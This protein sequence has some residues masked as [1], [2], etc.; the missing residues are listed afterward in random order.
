VDRGLLLV[1]PPGTGKTTLARA[2]SRACGIKF[3]VASATEWQAHGSLD[4]HL[5]AIRQTF[6]EARRYAPAILFLDEI[7]S[8]GSRE[9]LS[10]P[11]AQY[12]TEVING[13]L[14]Q[15]QGLDPGEPVIVIGATNYEEHVDPALRRAGRLDQVVR[16]PRPSVAALA[17][18]FE[19]HLAEHR[20]AG[21]V[22]NDVDSATLA[23]L[24][25]GLTGA[26]VEFFVRGAARR[27]RKERRPMAQADLVAEVT[28]RSRHPD[29]AHRLTPAE[30]RRVAVH[31]AGHALCALLADFAR[32]VPA[33]VSIVPRANGTLGF[34]ATA[35]AEGAVATRR[36]MLERL[37]T[38]LAGRAAEALVFGEDD[39][40]LG[41][42]GGRGSD[43]EVATRLATGLVCQAGLGAD[44]S[45]HWSDTPAPAQQ[46]QV[47]GLLRSAYEDAQRLLR[48]NRE[49]LERIAGALEREQELD[50][51]AVEALLGSPAPQPRQPSRRAGAT[52]QEACG[53]RVAGAGPAR[54]RPPR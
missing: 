22:A 16:L 14:E 18:I 48:R 2:I 19:H 34:V 32:Q 15:M 8:L 26:D 40:S 53:R 7:D 49:A 20:R 52:R 12:Q 5:R 41:S 3:V 33:F 10:G 27:A 13:V 47:E 44:G 28:G 42:G 45:L 11:N 43:L 24:A 4:A 51:A 23:A 37:R 36:E 9:R 1:G 38:I 29:G 50:G 35:P 30:M 6:A 25:F 21:A 54:G 31:E 17:Q 46:R 39:L